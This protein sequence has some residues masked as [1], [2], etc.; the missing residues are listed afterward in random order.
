MKIL[1]TGGG[2]AG[3][4]WPIILI[5]QSLIK[6]KRAKILYVGSRQGIEKYLVKNQ[7]IA[8]KSLITG[9]RRPYF[10]LSNYWDFF[11]IFIGLIQSLWVIL[12]FRPDVI[13]AKGGYVSF[14]IIF[15]LGFFKIPLVIHESDVVFGQTNLWA[16]KYAR[17]ICLGFPLEEYSEIQKKL[18][19]EK[20]VYTG[21]PVSRE[22]LQTAVR[23]ENHAK[24][25]ITGGSQGSSKINDLISEILPELL[26]KFEI[27]HVAG[28]RDFKKLSQNKS[29]NYHLFDLTFDLAKL[30]RDA[31]LVISRAGANTLAEIAATGIPSI[32][33]PLETAK[34]EHQTANARVFQKRNAAVVLSEKNLTPNSLLAIVNNLMADENLRKL[35]GHHARS[36]FQPKAAMEIID[37]L[38]EVVH[39][40]NN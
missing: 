10:S 36:L 6:N 39:E 21:V 19:L 38:F 11:K 15:W 1:L 18:P 16:A 2:T 27:Y 5:C 28:K 29:T 9:K 37:I 34:G 33:I 25:L 26:S 8:F 30:L 22:F 7:P 31:D 4:A 3:H 14:P 24:I 17:K 35:I 32:I 23:M 12:S 40:K 13:F 20:M